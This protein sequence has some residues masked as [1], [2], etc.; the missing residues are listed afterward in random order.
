ML[1]LV[2]E[3]VI[4]VMHENLI[5]FSLISLWIVLTLK[6]KIPSSVF[7]SSIIVSFLKVVQGAFFNIVSKKSL[8]SRIDGNVGCCPMVGVS[9][10]LSNTGVENGLFKGVTGISSNSGS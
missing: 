3:F 5:V 9:I 6:L 10:Y 7:C 1:L 8:V 4:D 2:I